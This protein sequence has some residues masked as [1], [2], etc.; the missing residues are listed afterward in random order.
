MFLVK[1]VKFEASSLW[2]S[3]CVCTTVQKCLSDL[4]PANRPVGHNDLS[5][6]NAPVEA[7]EELIWRLISVLRRSESL[8]AFLFRPLKGF[9]QFL[10]CEET[11]RQS[12]IAILEKA[13][14]LQFDEPELLTAALQQTYA[15]VKDK[16]KPPQID[17][18]RTFRWLIA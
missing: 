4:R 7:L 17:T 13:F 15:P 11:M 3:F 6:S 18:C 8:A 9:F 16:K 2:S 12:T 1:L 14:M 5:C 10:N